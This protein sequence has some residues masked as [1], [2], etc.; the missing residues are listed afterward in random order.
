MVFR[1]FLPGILGQLGLCSR[2][3]SKVDTKFL[4]EKRHELYFFG[5]EGWSLPL[6]S[7]QCSTQSEAEI[8]VEWTMSGVGPAVSSSRLGGNRPLC[9]CGFRRHGHRP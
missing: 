2:V 7:A 9:L 8:S 3:S 4:Q 5:G 6:P 1:Y